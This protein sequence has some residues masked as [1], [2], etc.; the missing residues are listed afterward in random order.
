[1]LRLYSLAWLNGKQIAGTIRRSMGSER[2]CPSKLISWGLPQYAQIGPVPA[3]EILRCSSPTKTVRPM[4]KG[5]PQSKQGAMVPG[6]TKQVGLEPAK[7]LKALLAPDN[8]FAF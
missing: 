3:P 2:L 4:K 8:W 1:M 6:L 7:S 5:N